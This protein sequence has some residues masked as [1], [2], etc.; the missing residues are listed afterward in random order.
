MFRATV[1]AEVHTTK[2]SPMI[3]YRPIPPLSLGQSNNWRSVLSAVVMAALLGT[4]AFG[5]AAEA[6]PEAGTQLSSAASAGTGGAGTGEGA[7]SGDAA[8]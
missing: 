6:A 4:A 5:T 7:S 1:G 2:E 3:A 8:G